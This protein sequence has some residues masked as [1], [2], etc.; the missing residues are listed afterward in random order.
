MFNNWIK[1]YLCNRSQY[2][3]INNINSN[4]ESI[5]CGVPQGSILGPLF[6]LIYINDIQNAVTPGVSKLYADDANIFVVSKDVMEL[7][8]SSNKILDNVLNWSILNKLSINFS[9][10][11]YT[12]F[13][14]SPR[15]KYDNIILKLGNSIIERE[16]AIK[17]L[18]MLLD[19]D[20]SWKSH[21]EENRKKLLKY[22][23][24]FYK[25][26][27]YLNYDCLRK[28]YFSTIFPT[29]SYGVEL[30]AN[31]TINILS[32]LKIS[33]NKILRILQNKPFRSPVSDL[34]KAFNTYDVCQLHEHKI[35]LFVH[36]VIYNTN[37]LPNSLQDYFT[38]QSK[39]SRHVLRGEHNLFLC[40]PRTEFGKRCLKFKAA[41]IWNKLSNDCKNLP[42]ISQFKRKIKLLI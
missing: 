19:S 31:T 29:L 42:S 33:N 3:H 15:D 7:N 17:Y 1:D 34:Y 39:L 37:N 13:S 14:K 22:A 23:G 32:V 35:L 5:S 10:T 4:I 11:N 6:F 8:L 26:R 16:T 24:I 30:Y 18:G 28:L 36:K 20:L 41:Q 21:I 9:K 38:L 25:I 40:S 12:I 27:P 2:V